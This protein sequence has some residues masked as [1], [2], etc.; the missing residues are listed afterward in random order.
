VLDLDRQHPA[1]VAVPAGEAK[2]VSE[3]ENVFAVPELDHACLIAS[4]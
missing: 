3:L 4:S 2:G 1:G